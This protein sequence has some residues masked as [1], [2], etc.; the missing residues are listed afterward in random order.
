MK[1]SLHALLGGNCVDQPSTHVSA[2]YLGSWKVLQQKAKYILH[3]PALEGTLRGFTIHQCASC[4]GSLK[5]LHAEDR[6]HHACA[7]CR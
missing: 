2:G 3:V 5:D 7:G 4:S 6:M 1:H